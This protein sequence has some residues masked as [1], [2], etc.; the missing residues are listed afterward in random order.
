MV[1]AACSFFNASVNR[2]IEGAK[3]PNNDRYERDFNAKVTQRE[4]SN[5]D[6]C[7]GEKS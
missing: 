2:L 3:R 1:K 5:S 6:G 7:W 4:I